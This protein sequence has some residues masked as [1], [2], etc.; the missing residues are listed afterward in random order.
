M[1]VILYNNGLS[2]EKI[3]S[4][5]VTNRIGW[6][7]LKQCMQYFHYVTCARVRIQFREE[8]TFAIEN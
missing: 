3:L 8:Q 7:S 6:S 2:D 1:V 5:F 4:K